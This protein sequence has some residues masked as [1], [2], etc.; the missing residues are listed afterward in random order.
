MSSDIW[1]SAKQDRAPNPGRD[2]IL[3]LMNS[4]EPASGCYSFCLNE[5]KNTLAQLRDS[6]PDQQKAE[7]I[8]RFIVHM[9]RVYA[10]N[11]YHPDGTILVQIA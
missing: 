5:A 8:D 4:M 2:A 7:S 3:V 9:E 10:E 1:I 11:R 6:Q